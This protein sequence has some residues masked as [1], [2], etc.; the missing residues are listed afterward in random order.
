MLLLAL[1][2]SASW[3]FCIGPCTLGPFQRLGG[4]ETENCE[5][6]SCASCEGESQPSEPA[7]GSRECLAQCQSLRFAIA[8]APTVAPAWALESVASVP[9]ATPARLSLVS[10]ASYRQAL[11]TGPPFARSFAELVL[12]TS[13]L[14]HAP[15]RTA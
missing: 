12:Q 1:L 15:P 9:F 11:D 6:G 8:P 5:G 10:V 14:S 13:L 3:L 7:G 2:A 4:M